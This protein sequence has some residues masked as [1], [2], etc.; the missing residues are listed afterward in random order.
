MYSIRELS[1]QQSSNSDRIDEVRADLAE[2]ELR[3]D[4]AEGQIETLEAHLA[5]LTKDLEGRIKPLAASAERSERLDGD[6]V[7]AVRAG[8]PKETGNG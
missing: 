7:A 3:V 5:E 6:L 1:E 8:A 4:S 2:L